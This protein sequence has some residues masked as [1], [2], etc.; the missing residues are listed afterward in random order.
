M[1]FMNAIILLKTYDAFF[2][3]GQLQIKKCI[4]FEEYSIV[5]SAARFGVHDVDFSL[6]PPLLSH[7]CPAKARASE[8]HRKRART[9]RDRRRDDILSPS[10]FQTPDTPSFASAPVAEA[11]CS[12]SLPPSVRKKRETNTGNSGSVYDTGSTPAPVPTSDP[13]TR[14]YCKG[15]PKPTRIFAPRIR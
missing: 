1:E 12:I 13:L 8:R 6:S 11:K 5:S 10:V 2:W 7:S 9:V 14:Q 3:N 15:S 4:F